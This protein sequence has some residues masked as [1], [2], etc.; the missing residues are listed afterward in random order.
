MK[1]NLLI[2]YSLIVLGTLFAYSQGHV[3]STENLSTLA[4][5]SDGNPN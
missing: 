2:A 1:I 4:S 5:A 3:F